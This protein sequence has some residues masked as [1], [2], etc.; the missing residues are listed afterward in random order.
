[1]REL[2]LTDATTGIADVFADIVALAEACRFTDCWH[3]TEPGCAVKAALEAGSLDADRVKRWRKLSAENARNDAT[4][5]E[6]R[7]TERN[8][9][10]MAKHIMEHKRRRQEE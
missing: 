3:E 6:R 1:M 5:A 8:F 4:L 10:R 7:A 2:Q 9:G